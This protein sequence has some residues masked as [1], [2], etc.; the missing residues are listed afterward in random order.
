M[1]GGR[2]RSGHGTAR[3][4]LMPAGYGADTSTMPLH[5]LFG[6]IAFGSIAV[7][8]LWAYV[9]WPRLRPATLARAAVNVAV[10][11]VSFA[12]TPM[13]VTTVMHETPGRLAVVVAIGG[14]LVP[15]LTYVFLSWIWLLAR[16][17]EG[18]DSGP[19]G[20]LPVREG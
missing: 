2:T 18:T 12:A 16:I 8:A 10:S 17:V 19:R 4:S 15:S 6:P 14:I 11:F 1:Q 7:L 20:G 13:I 3:L 9:R 5:E